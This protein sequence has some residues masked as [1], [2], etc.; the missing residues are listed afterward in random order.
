VLVPVFEFF[1][2]TKANP[3]RIALRNGVQRI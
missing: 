1:E 2:K 3:Q